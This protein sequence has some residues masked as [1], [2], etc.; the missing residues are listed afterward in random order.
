MKVMELIDILRKLPQ[1]VNVFF[2][3][4]DSD[5]VLRLVKG[6]DTN[7]T[8]YRDDENDNNFDL[9]VDKDMIEPKSNEK[10]QSMKGI[11]LLP[12]EM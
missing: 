12:Y 4:N 9:L 3:I 2:S 7:V 8:Y 5:D 6:V 11:L 1:D 10:A